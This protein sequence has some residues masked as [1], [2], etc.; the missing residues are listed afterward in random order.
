MALTSEEK[1]EA[2]DLAKGMLLA[3][4]DNLS[5]AGNLINNPHFSG[6]PHRVKL[7]AMRQYADMEDSGEY[8]STVNV[9]PDKAKMMKSIAG[10][11]FRDGTLSLPLAGVLAVAGGSQASTAAGVPDP[12][13]SLMNSPRTA[14]KFARRLAPLAAALFASNAV[15]G[16]IREGITQKK[17]L[18]RTRNANMYL[19]RVRANMSDAEINAM[20][21][22]S[23]EMDRR[24]INRAVA[25]TQNIDNIS[26]I[27]P[28]VISMKDLGNAKDSYPARW[29]SEMGAEAERD[30][31]AS[32]KKTAEDYGIKVPKPP[33][34]T[35]PPK[36][37]M[38]SPGPTTLRNTNTTPG[39]KAQ[40]AKIR[41]EQNKDTMSSF[42]DAVSMGGDPD[43]QFR[44]AKAAVKKLLRVP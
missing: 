30:Y 23:S 38:S 33:K 3:Q 17:E 19:D 18:D 22:G 27:N 24:V 26:R 21:L 13:E 10:A 32:L 43:A 12:A 20:L 14:K 16:G 5:L 39:F 25:S 29:Y 6:I 8:K 34:A 4:K 42:K 44:T 15:I 7:E 40:S 28:A 37:N 31:E 1:Q 2:L 41:N 9:E 35:K 11:A 36:I